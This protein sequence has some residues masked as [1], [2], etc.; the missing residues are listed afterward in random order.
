LGS[1]AVDEPGVGT[2]TGVMVVRRRTVV[3]LDA[4][5]QLGAYHELGD[6]WFDRSRYTA[7]QPR[8]IVARLQ[9]LG[10]TVTLQP[11]A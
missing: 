6:D 11:A 9:R 10:H 8:R 4:L 7:A 3:G 2:L 5:A 1:V